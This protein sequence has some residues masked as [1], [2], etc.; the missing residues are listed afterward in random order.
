[1]LEHL[2]LNNELAPTVCP[3]TEKSWGLS[4]Q[5]A[6][7]SYGARFGS[8]RW[9]KCLHRDLVRLCRPL[10]SNGERV[11]QSIE[12]ASTSR[13]RGE[14]LVRCLRFNEPAVEITF[15]VLSSG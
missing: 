1:M 4:L 14:T 7:S 13:H 8:I 10:G 5:L 9:R 2:T 6:R 3:M 15:L 12:V 11:K